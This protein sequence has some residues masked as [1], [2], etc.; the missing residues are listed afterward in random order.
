M[1]KQKKWFVLL[2]AFFFGIAMEAI[3][4]EYFTKTAY[5][6]QTMY[7]AVKT[8]DGD[9]CMRIS[10]NS[11]AADNTAAAENDSTSGT[12]ADSVD[13]TENNGAS[14]AEENTV[15]EENKVAE[16]NTAA[17]E[18]STSGRKES[19]EAEEN[20]V[21]TE[22]GTSGEVTAQDIWLSAYRNL[23][24]G[25]ESSLEKVAALAL[26]D[27]KAADLELMSS[28]TDRVVT[29]HGRRFAI[30]AEDYEVLLKIVEAEASTEDIKGKMLVANVIMNRL[31]VGFCGNTIVE[32]V[33]AEGQFAP[34]ANGRFFKMV[35]S[36]ET[37]EAV[38]RVLNGE[39]LSKG[40]LYFMQRN[41][42]SK[43]GIRWFDEN[44]K[45][46]FEY[47]C[48]EFYTEKN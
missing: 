5:A 34:V 45:F 18:N 41:A 28:S 22:N 1:L 24:Y 12:A 13:A 33:F 38:E 10:Q 4:P 30:T 27:V 20:T 48:H 16:E 17:E 40:A 43:K 25:T 35:P 37:I 15:A 42:A 6:M 31:E 3:V 29:Y 8:H 14:V 2:A 46:L 44:L 19:T 36:E 7:V 21:G 26:S 9:G 39:D 11:I 32:V 23:M 47:G